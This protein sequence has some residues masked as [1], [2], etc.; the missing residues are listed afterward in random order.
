MASFRFLLAA[1]LCMLGVTQLA[2]AEG[3]IAIQDLPQ[4]VV[5]TITTRY[6][7]AKL[8][9]ARQTL[10]DKVVVYE[11]DLTNDKTLIEIA[12]LADG[13]IDWVLVDLPI[14][15]LPKAILAGIRKKYPAAKLTDASTVYTV[16]DGKDQLEHYAVELQTKGGK[17]RALDVLPDGTIEEDEETTE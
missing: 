4:P 2:I 9:E 12:V 3:V 15:D 7:K 14:A 1:G 13:T 6:P 11:V 5:K 8:T 16:K 10:E 17:H